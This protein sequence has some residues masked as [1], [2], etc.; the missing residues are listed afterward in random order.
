MRR[1]STGVECCFYA[2]TF[3]ETSP[4][5]T[6]LF[7]TSLNR[8]RDAMHCVSTMKKIGWYLFF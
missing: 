3:H 8:G 2:E 7:A 5:Q 1:G 4:Q 6:K